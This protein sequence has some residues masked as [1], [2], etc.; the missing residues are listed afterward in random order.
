[1]NEKNDW[2]MTLFILAGTFTWTE[3]RIAI[4]NFSE[5]D[6]SYGLFVISNYEISNQTVWSCVWLSLLLQILIKFFV[7]RKVR[8]F[9]KSMKEN[10]GQNEG[11]MRRRKSNEL[12]PEWHWM[13]LH[14]LMI[15]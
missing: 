7:D 10:L 6:F 11:V 9:N 8:V 15:N 4:N 5:N 2:L 14:N 12:S 13:T 1:M 3:Q